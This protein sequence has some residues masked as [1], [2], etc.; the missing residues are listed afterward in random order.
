MVCLCAGFSWNLKKKKKSY[1]RE[2]TLG[3]CI[4]VS[5]G[6]RQKAFVVANKVRGPACVTKQTVEKCWLSVRVMQTGVAYVPHKTAKQTIID[7]VQ[8][9]AQEVGGGGFLPPPAISLLL[10]GSI[11]YEKRRNTVPP[12]SVC[13]EPLP[14]TVALTFSFVTW[15]ST[16]QLL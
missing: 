14:T 5:S 16:F 8:R 9:W 2:G 4:L 1:S 13:S 7:N 15:V 6:K 3:L 11:F 12:G 10:W